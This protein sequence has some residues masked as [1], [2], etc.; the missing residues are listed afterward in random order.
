MLMNRM[1]A[2]F[3][4]TSL[5]AVTAE[6]ADAQGTNS[7]FY[8]APG[9]RYVPAPQYAAPRAVN[10]VVAPA[11]CPTCP[12]Q[13]VNGNCPMPISGGAV[14]RSGYVY[15]AYGRRILVRYYQAP[16]Y[17]PVMRTPAGNYSAPANGSRAQPVNVPPTQVPNNYRQPVS[18]N[19]PANRGYGQPGTL[20]APS[21]QPRS[22]G[23]SSPFYP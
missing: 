14:M 22:G 7:P 11:S 2:M 23:V 8:S 17:Q 18:R 10:G 4:A 19:A 6:S 5:F 16:S 12:P 3:V 9:A 21:P 15:D 20:T 1:A 13:C